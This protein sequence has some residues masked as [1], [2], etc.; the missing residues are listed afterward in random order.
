MDYGIL[1]F[2]EIKKGYRYNSESKSFMCNYCERAFPEG[3]VFPSGDVFYPPEQAAARHIEDEH[4]GNAV[5]LLYTDT[6]YNTLTDNQK[7]LLSLFN[8]GMSDGEIAKKLGVSPSTVRHQKFMFREKAKQA[9]L[10]L[11]MFEHIFSA[12]LANSEAIIPIHNNATYLDDRYVITVQ[13]R[14]HILETSFESFDPLK[15][16]D[17]SPKEKKKVVILARIAE[18]FKVGA[19]YTEKEVNQILKPVYGDYPLIRRYL[20]MYGFMKRADD[21]SS[22]WLA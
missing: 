19:R 18:Q 21:G 12:R 22:Y 1:T 16:K 4:G 3:Q 6:K 10:Y 9:K 11:A 5:Q 15:L 13:E 7:E 2:D 14:G 8:S 17:F 20:I